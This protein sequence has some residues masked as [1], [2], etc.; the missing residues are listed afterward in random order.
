MCITP[1]AGLQYAKSRLTD[2]VII[3]GEPE[4]IVDYI[5]TSRIHH[6]K[7]QYQAIWQGHNPDPTWY[8]AENFK[9]SSVKLQEFHEA[10]TS[11]SG[12]PVR[13]HNWLQAAADDQDAGDHG[14]DN[15]PVSQENRGL[16][17]RRNAR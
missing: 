16:R 5:F 15:T 1:V 12:P 10:N 6:G 3:N 4:W 9:N 11:A 8:D 2:S 17:R 13:L 7:L 14:D